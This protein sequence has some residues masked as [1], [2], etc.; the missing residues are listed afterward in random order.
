MILIIFFNFFID[1]ATKGHKNVVIIATTVPV[2]ILLVICVI[3]AIVKCRPSRK[4]QQEQITAV[5]TSG[6]LQLGCLPDPNI[7]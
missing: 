2:S 7:T 3:I 6:L 5:T 4:L 1:F